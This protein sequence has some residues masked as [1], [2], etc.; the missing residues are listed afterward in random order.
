MVNGQEVI[1]MDQNGIMLV[2]CDDLS[3]L[4]ISF[5]PRPLKKCLQGVEVG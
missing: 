3:I 5:H 4:I 1:K 2:K